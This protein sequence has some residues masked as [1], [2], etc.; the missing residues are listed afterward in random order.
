M[1]APPV[2]GVMIT[3]VCDIIYVALGIVVQ[4]VPEGFWTS[5]HGLTTIELVVA[6]VSASNNP[7]GFPATIVV[8]E[9]PVALD[10]FVHPVPDAFG[11]S[12]HVVIL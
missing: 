10:I 9:P 5:T 6:Y 3:G 12:L 11:M 1:E 8:E 4:E 7:I 2:P